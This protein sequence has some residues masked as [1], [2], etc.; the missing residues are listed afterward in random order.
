MR[1]DRVLLVASRYPNQPRALWHLPGGRQRWNELLAQTVEREVGEETGLRARVGELLYVSESTDGQTQFTNFTFH[2]E[3]S[4][5]PQ[6]PSSTID[7]VEAAA[8]V[9][10]DE[11]EKRIAVRVVREPLIAH[12]RGARER[13]YGFAEA[14]I[15][16]EFPD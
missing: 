6:A 14:G 11:L 7:H 9:P 5:E 2:I 13:Y 15:S 1:G 16:I 8:F 10:L 12:L 4:G 3:A